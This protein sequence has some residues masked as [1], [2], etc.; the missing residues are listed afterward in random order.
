MSGEAAVPTVA[1]SVEKMKVGVW[2]RRSFHHVQCFAAVRMKQLISQS[3]GIKVS[4]M[5]RSAT[6]RIQNLIQIN[7]INLQAVLLASIHKSNPT[8]E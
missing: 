4:A 8:T 1:A 2:S 3:E 5:K 6:E 7:F